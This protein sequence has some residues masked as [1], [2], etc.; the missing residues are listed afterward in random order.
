MDVERVRLLQQVL[1]PKGRLSYVKMQFVLL[2]Q[3]R[4]KQGRNP[5][6]NPHKNVREGGRPAGAGLVVVVLRVVAVA[7]NPAPQSGSC[8]IHRVRCDFPSET[9]RRPS[10]YA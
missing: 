6:K 7:F 2:R 1:L 5:R 3:C 10:R 8:A 9:F 4:R